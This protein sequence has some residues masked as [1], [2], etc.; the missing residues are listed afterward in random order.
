MQGCRSQSQFRQLNVQKDGQMDEQ[1]LQ[2]D[3][4]LRKEDII[5]TNGIII[6]F[7]MTSSLQR[8][9]CLIFFVDAIVLS[10]NDAIFCCK[11]KQLFVM[12]SQLP[13]GGSNRKPEVNKSF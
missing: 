13:R 3:I 5:G 11:A 8:F 9:N 10:T 6:D 1:T 4:I 7:L 2:W 12:F